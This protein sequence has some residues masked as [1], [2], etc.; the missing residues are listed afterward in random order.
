MNKLQLKLLVGILLAI[1]LGVF[2]YKVFVLGFPLVPAEK[3]SAWNVEAHVAF[4]GKNSPVKVVL[5]TLNRVSGFAVTDE[6]FIG[7]GYGRQRVSQRITDEQV[8]NE[9]YDQNSVV[10]WS[11]RLADGKQDLIYSAVLRPESIGEFPK[12][13]PPQEIPELRDPQFSEAEAVAANALISII[14]KES[15][16]MESFVPLLMQE[17]QHSEKNSNAAYLL[18]NSKNNRGVVN[19]AVRLLHLSGIPAQAVHGI[20][21]GTSSDARISHWLELYQN[22]AW[23]MFDVAKG[24]F[25]T[26]VNFVP[27]W[28]G[29]A[30]LAEI[31]GGKNL[32]VS[33]SV[34]PDAI[35]AMRNVVDRIETTHPTFFDYSLFSLPVQ[36]QATY[37]VILLIPIGAILLVFLRNVIGFSTF[38]TFMPVLIALSFRETQLLWGVGL[39]S[40]VIILGLGVRLYLEHLKLLLVPRLACVLITVVLLMAGISV[41]CFKLGIPRG[42]SVSLFPM[43]ILSMTIERISVMW[44]EMGAG[45]AIQ[46]AVASM[47]VAVLAFLVMTNTYVEHLFFVFP[48]LFLVLLALTMMMGRYTGYRLLDLVRFRTF[49]RG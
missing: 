44:D 45:K 24:V 48:E 49:L 19:V 3:T 18:R 34:V 35:D 1:G 28:R 30:P 43:V 40:V 47:A 33:L 5:Q 29:D 39:F 22:D 26:P 4:D 27:W 17:L 10:I 15:A 8:T 37:R 12:W 36:A 11:K 38:G 14:G 9:A 2:S 21:L 25:S 32:Q 31:R 23:H 41:V 13:S 7:A 6:F 16:D 20:T 46:Q 42:V